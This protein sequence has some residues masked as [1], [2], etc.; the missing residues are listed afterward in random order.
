[1]YIPAEEIWKYW[2][3]FSFQ[4]CRAVRTWA[5]KRY[6]Y[7]IFQVRKVWIYIQ[8]WILKALLFYI[9]PI[10]HLIKLDCPE[11]SVES[12]FSFG[13]GII[14]RDCNPRSLENGGRRIPIS[15]PIWMIHKT[16]SQNWDGRRF[17]IDQQNKMLPTSIRWP[18]FNIHQCKI[19]KCIHQCKMN[20]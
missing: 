12:K 16:L 4:Y 3:V 20:K 19:N 6:M 10:Y 9:C 7:M 13:M 5:F 15:R 17:E 18:W 2:T 11:H 14:A 8:I 1:M